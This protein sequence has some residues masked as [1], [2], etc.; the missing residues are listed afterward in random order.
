MA[1]FGTNFVVY[2][3]R[4]VRLFTARTTAVTAYCWRLT[5]PPTEEGS[6]PPPQKILRFFHLKWLILVQIQLYFNRNVRQFLLGPQQLL[7]TCTAGGWGFDRASRTLLASRPPSLRSWLSLKYGAWSPERDVT[8]N[9]Y[10]FRGRPN[11]TTT[12]CCFALWA[13]SRLV[14]ANGGVVTGETRGSCLLH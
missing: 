1:H 3:N 5:G 11:A 10:R 2:F 6:Q 8:Y 4:N 13:N 14:V 12:R 7:Y 9:L